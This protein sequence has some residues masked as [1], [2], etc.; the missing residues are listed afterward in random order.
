MADVLRQIKEGD[1]NSKVKN[2]SLAKPVT[3]KVE[4]K[5]LSLGMDTV[6]G[7]PNGIAPQ[8]LDTVDGSSGFD[9]VDSPGGFDTVDSSSVGFDTVDSSMGFDTVDSGLIRISISENMQDTDEVQ[10]Q[11]SS[12]LLTARTLKRHTSHTPADL[13]KQ[14]LEHAK[15]RKEVR[16]CAPVQVWD[17]G[18]QAIFYTTHQTF[19]SPRCVYTLVIDVSRKLFDLVDD[20]DLNPGTMMKSKIIGKTDNF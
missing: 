1:L 15:E 7:I 6:D 12:S 8:G 11:N 5:T 19:L 13:L 18:G 20:T 14:T 16:N 10:F 3:E 9:T 2:D 4:N 17:F